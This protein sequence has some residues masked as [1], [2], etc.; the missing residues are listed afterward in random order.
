[1]GEHSEGF[2]FKTKKKVILEKEK[3]T[4]VRHINTSINQNEK[5]QITRYSLHLN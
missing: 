5:N 4:E 3:R 1:M 2:T